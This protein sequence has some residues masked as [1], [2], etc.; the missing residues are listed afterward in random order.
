M[1]EAEGG[2][3]E[4]LRVNAPWLSTPVAS[5]PSGT[6]QMEVA[7]NFG[8]RLIAQGDLRIAQR[9][10]TRQG[11]AWCSPRSRRP[12][13]RFR[14][15]GRRAWAVAGEDSSWHARLAPQGRGPLIP[16]ATGRAFGNV[17]RWRHSRQGLRRKTRRLVS[18][19]VPGPARFCGWACRC[20]S[21]R[22][23]VV[24]GERPP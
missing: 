5:Q 13:S 16:L 23:P 9:W 11:S 20:A 15:V 12:C 19:R 18:W 17:K 3:L 4:P 22:L 6:F 21:A 1:N 24:L 14:R 7:T 10:G 8:R 2:G